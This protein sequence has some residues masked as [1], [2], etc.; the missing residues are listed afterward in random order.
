MTKRLDVLT[1]VAALVRAALPTAE[2]LSLDN[3]AAAPERVPE[4]GRVVVRAGDPG[5]PQVDLSPLTY[6][7]EH[8]IPVEIMTYGRGAM[9]PEAVLDQMLTALS[10][11]IM[12]SRTLGGVVDWLDAVAPQTGDIF[13]SG[14]RPVRSATAIFTASY[15]TTSPL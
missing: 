8:Q 5:D 11:Q 7:Y 13:H 2:V 9:A 12:A 3:D 15:S 6:N 14:A 10:A 4:N 1:A